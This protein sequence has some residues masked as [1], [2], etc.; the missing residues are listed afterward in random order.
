MSTEIIFPDDKLKLVSFFHGIGGM[1]MGAYRAGFKSMY[2]TDN[3]EIAKRVFE[4]NKSSGFFDLCDF[5]KL[6]VERILEK[7]NSHFKGLSIKAGDIDCVVSGSPCQGMSSVNPKRKNFDFRNLMMAKQVR[8]AGMHGLRTKV[9]WFEQVPGFFDEPMKALRM[10]I[11]ATLEAQTDYNYAIQVLNAVD[12]GSYQ[13]RDRVTIIMVRKDIGMPSFPDHQPTTL[14]KCCMQS[15]L[16]YVTAFKY[17]ND[18]FPKCAKSNVINTMTTG[19]DGLMV[20]DGCNWRTITIDE[21]KLLC[22]LNGFDFGN[23][24]PSE[25]LKLM[26]NMVQIPFAEAIMQHIKNEILF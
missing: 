19:G 16:P 25:K 23:I 2:A 21:R 4:L 26:G 14:E 8:L 15:A 10:E 1:A 22:H 12:Y 7:I 3:W 13:S 6:S 5:R 24:K 11:L 9:A 17:G 18:G 20:F